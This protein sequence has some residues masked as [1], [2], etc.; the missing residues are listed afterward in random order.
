MITSSNKLLSFIGMAIVYLFFYRA[1]KAQGFD[2]SKLPYK[3]WLQPFCGWFGLITMFIV[4]CCYGY[5]IYLPGNFTVG[6]F[7][8]YYLMVF[9][10][11]IIYVGW[12]LYKKTRIIPA[13]EVDL[14]WEAPAIDAYEATLVEENDDNLW[15]AVKKLL[16]LK[17]TE[18][19]A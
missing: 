19:I 10:N 8:I 17:K 14:I 2:R 11:I 6:D 15:G 16:K 3:G 9:V 13:K 1:M 4:L 18:H 7:F 5:A 12:K